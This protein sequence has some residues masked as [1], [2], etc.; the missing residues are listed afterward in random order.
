MSGFLATAMLIVASFACS[1][2]PVRAPTPTSD[3]TI[4]TLT[5]LVTERV[6]L[7]TQVA[8][9]ETVRA[10]VAT[11]V[12]ILVT[13]SVASATSVASTTPIATPR[14]RTTSTIELAEEYFSAIV[15][16]DREGA[17][18]LIGA[19]PWCTPIDVGEKFEGHL[20]MLGSTQ[21]RNVS[22]EAVNISGHVA[23]PPG[24]EAA[25]IFFEYKG[26]NSTE[27]RS[28]SIGIVTSSYMD[29]GWRFICDLWR[30]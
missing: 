27:W 28:A 17:R 7:A 16:G 23:Y 12:T 18:S 20:A 1:S 26:A 21:V 9:V 4:V 11:Q 19:D 8:E 5:A 15:D 2:R 3:Y 6:Y 13:E 10:S 29:S 30:Q 24:A 14:L 22:I 25:R